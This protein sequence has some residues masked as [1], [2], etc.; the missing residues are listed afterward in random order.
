MRTLNVVFM[1]LFV[2]LFWA[3]KAL[4]ATTPGADGCS[5]PATRT[6]TT[7]RGDRLN[8]PN[9]VLTRFGTT[10]NELRGANPGVLVPVA[11]LK[12]A[13]GSPYEVTSRTIAVTRLRWYLPPGR[14]ITIPLSRA[15]LEAARRCE[16]G[17]AN[18]LESELATLRAENERLQT[19]RAAQTRRVK[20]AEARLA[21]ARHAN[22]RMRQSGLY[23]WLTIGTVIALILVVSAAKRR[24]PETP[25]ITANAP[26]DRSA[27]RAEEFM[28]RER[29]V[30]TNEVELQKRIAEVERR[31]GEIRELRAQ[32]ASI[33]V[34]LDGQRSAL[35]R[36][37]EEQDSRARELAADADAIRNAREDLMRRE[38]AHE[39]LT[40]ERTRDIS[41]AA[42]AAV[43]RAS[44]KPPEGDGTEI[45]VL[46]PEAVGVKSYESLP[47]LPPVAVSIGPPEG[48]GRPPA[49]EVAAGDEDARA[50]TLHGVQ[51][52]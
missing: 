40:A 3:G 19:S 47:S 45:P 25:A 26:S 28:A 41:S 30:R 20:R 18:R 4:A 42:S 50:T 9:G 36:R 51:V 13:A 11:R 49:A 34:G 32:F 39:A 1:T 23:G 33:Q 52:H 17:R 24:R 31:E 43:A 46:D 10:V 8:G 2:V 5:V 37:R 16:Q 7:V 12:I 38:A 14:T 15:A 29:Q 48:T 35:D 22:Q 27:A 6:Y 44:A 21:A